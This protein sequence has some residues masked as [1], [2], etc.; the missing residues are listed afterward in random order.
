MLWFNF[1]FSCD[2]IFDHSYH[3]L[4]YIKAKENK[5]SVN[6]NM[7]NY[8]YIPDTIVYFALTDYNLNKPCFP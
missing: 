7:Y 4:L 5:N 3:T 1:Y 6:H 2:F 8:I